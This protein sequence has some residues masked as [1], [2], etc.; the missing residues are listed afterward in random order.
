MI[1]DR[2]TRWLAEA[3]V[4]CGIAPD[5]PRQFTLSVHKDLMVFDAT[6]RAHL[7]PVPD[8]EVAEAWRGVTERTKQRVLA[9]ASG[10]IWR[11]ICSSE[12]AHAERMHAQDIVMSQ[13]SGIGSGFVLSDKGRRMAAFGQAIA[14]ALAELDDLPG[15]T[16]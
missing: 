5:D 3:K 14:R 15:V 13:D 4:R 1:R 11:P 9:L 6:G 2:R 10:A 7:V 8:P 16:P 12:Q